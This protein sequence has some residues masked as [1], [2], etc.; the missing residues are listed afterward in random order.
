MLRPW[1]VVADLSLGMLDLVDSAPGQKGSPYR[2][3]RRL[4]S[5]N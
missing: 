5:Q 1:V 2:W 4:T 3:R